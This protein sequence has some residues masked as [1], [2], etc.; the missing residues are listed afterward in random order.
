MKKIFLLFAV[1]MLF[2]PLS[3]A[4]DDDYGQRGNGWGHHE[5]EHHR[6]YYQPQGGYY[7]QQYPTQ[8]YQQPQGGY[9][10]QQQPAVIYQQPQVIYSQPPQYGN[11]FRLSW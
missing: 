3:Y 1:F 8:S 4:D 10:Y 7:Q 9:Y 5:Y 6:H 11:S 2:S